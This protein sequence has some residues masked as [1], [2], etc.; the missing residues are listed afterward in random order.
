[1]ALLDRHAH[2]GVRPAIHDGRVPV[3]DHRLPPSRAV[4]DGL[5]E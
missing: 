4:V 5:G 3:I 1:M 2:I